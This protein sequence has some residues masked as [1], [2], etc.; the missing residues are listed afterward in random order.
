MALFDDPDLWAE[1]NF[2]TEGASPPSQWE[3]L[4]TD[5]RFWFVGSNPF[6]GGDPA[7]MIY[8]GPTPLAAQTVTLAW[9][10][11]DVPDFSG[12]A[13]MRWRFA[14]GDGYTQVDLG[15][16]L[17]SGEVEIEI[18]EGTTY[19]EFGV[20]QTAGL[21]YDTTV[22]V[23][24]V[25]PARIDLTWTAGVAGTYPLTGDHILQKAVT[26]VGGTAIEADFTEIVQQSYIAARVYSDL[27]IEAGNTY[28][29]RVKT[30]DSQG[31]NTV[32][33]WSNVVS[34]PYEEV[35]CEI[36]SLDEAAA[37]AAPMINIDG[38]SSS[39]QI[40]AVALSDGNA[41]RMLVAAILMDS[42]IGGEIQYD[43]ITMDGLPADVELGPFPMGG[44]AVVLVAWLIDELGITDTTITVDFP[45]TPNWE[46]T[47]QIFTFG[48]VGGV[49]YQKGTNGELSEN[50][51]VLDQVGADGSAYINTMVFSMAGMENYLSS[52][53]ALIT[54]T[55][56]S[57]GTYADS[58]GGGTFPD[59]GIQLNFSIG[60]S[61][62]LAR[63]NYLIS[64]GFN[65]GLVGW[66]FDNP[67]AEDGSLLYDTAQAAFAVYSL[68]DA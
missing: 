33:E 59:D 22:A 21:I 60:E 41:N 35:V 40:D 58:V 24:Q 8:I 47:A 49:F 50:P 51:A 15:S 2:G 31:S 44:G 29:Y 36:Y 18:P 9:E 32:P 11:T 64:A 1:Y 19:F 62:Y 34:I 38:F 20:A 39:A 45:G 30:S 14:D 13:K 67:D 46:L 28:H 65:F 25:T 27:D 5:G 56:P 52:P 16:T 55:E 48:N 3:A 12:S 10:M 26:D 54:N 37:T 7:M 61:F 23:G 43:G 17:G 42:S 53:L 57:G 68:C 4:D 63:A 66:S 6:G